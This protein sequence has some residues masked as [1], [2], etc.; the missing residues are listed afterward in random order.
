MKKIYSILIYFT[1]LLFPIL[2]HGDIR[3]L[4]TGAFEVK[5]TIIL[6]GTPEAVFDAV[7][8][9]ISEWWD[10]SFSKSPL[11][12]YIESRP[13]G[14]FYEIFD[15]QGNGVK[16]AEVIVSDRGKMLRFDGPLGLSGMAI[17]IVST[18][19]LEPAGSDS[20]RFTLTVHAAGESTE[21]LA[22]T[23]DKVWYHFL[24]ERLKPYLINRNRREK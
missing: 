9:D 21:G 7:T 18:Y 23:V 15:E 14:G 13:G 8:G 2:S 17:K 3:N 16:H 10:H 5:Y 11:K 6:P 4:T 24:F 22:E 19:E 1:I 12:F 20:T